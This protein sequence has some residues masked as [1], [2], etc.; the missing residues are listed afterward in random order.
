M[1]RFVTTVLFCDNKGTVS[2]THDP[3]SHSQMKHIDIRVHFI[4]DCVNS[5]II[6]VHHIS[7][8]DNTVDVLTKPLNK[9]IHTKWL[10]CLRMD[11][12]QGGV[13]EL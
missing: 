6:D 1:L 11:E 4:R 5:K 13:S 12:G 10:K 2:C 8:V 9:V 3:H 7:G